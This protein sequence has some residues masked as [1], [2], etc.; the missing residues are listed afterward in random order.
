MIKLGI[1]RES[2]I[3]VFAALSN[4]GK[5]RAINRIIVVL[6]NCLDGELSFQLVLL[7][8]LH[9]STPL[10]MNFGS[11]CSILAAAIRRSFLYC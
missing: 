9:K 4:L 8:L 6:N 11:E 3:A 1:G 10:R 7:Q 2:P 5:R